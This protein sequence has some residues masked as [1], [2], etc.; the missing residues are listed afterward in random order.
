[1]RSAEISAFNDYQ[2]SDV[3]AGQKI[4][5]IGY[6]TGYFDQKNFLP[7]LRGGTIASIPEVPFNGLPQILVDAQVLPGSSGSPVYVEKGGKYKL[8]GIVN[9]APLREIESIEVVTEEIVNSVNKSTA[10]RLYVQRIGLGTIFNITT[11]NDICR[12]ASEPSN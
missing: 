9:A 2:L 7:V 8:L 11:I 12:Q 3:H 6:P 5:F 10:N 1:M 4:V